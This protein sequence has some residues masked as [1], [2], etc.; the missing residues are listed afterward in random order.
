MKMNQPKSYQ[1]GELVSE[2]VLNQRYKVV[3]KMGGYIAYDIGGTRLWT[4]LVFPTKEN[5]NLPMGST[6]I[7]F[8]FVRNEND[9]SM[10]PSC[11]YQKGA[12]LEERLK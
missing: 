2:Q 5:P 10:I 9:S 4:R 8:G 7:M 11:I 3:A 6:E 1:I 12:V